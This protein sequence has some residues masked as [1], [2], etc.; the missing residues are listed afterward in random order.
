MPY[1]APAAPA[2]SA[3]EAESA[4]IEKRSGMARSA[5]RWAFAAQPPL[6]LNP[7]MPT[8]R[9]AVVPDIYPAIRVPGVK[10]TCRLSSAWIWKCSINWG[11]G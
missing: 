8:P 7:M 9:G 4:R 5:S 6:A 10:V 3:V 1:A 11:A 2:L